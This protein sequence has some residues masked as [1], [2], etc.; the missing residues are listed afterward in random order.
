MK[1]SLKGGFSMMG[2]GSPIEGKAQ[3]I[4]MGKGFNGSGIRREVPSSSGGKSPFVA[5]TRTL[6]WGSCHHNHVLEDKKDKIN[7]HK[8]KARKSGR[9][10]GYWGAD[11]LSANALR[12]GKDIFARRKIFYKRL[13]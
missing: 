8:K 7:P 6:C 3:I 12:R 13:P 1:E 4:E 2:K 9:R 11:G 5:G 10:K